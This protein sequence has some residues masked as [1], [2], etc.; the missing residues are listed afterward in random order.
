LELD[1]FA[2]D[3]NTKASLNGA[4]VTIEDLTDPDNPVLVQ[5]NEL[6]NNFNFSLDK[7]KKYRITATKPGYRSAT[8]DIDT[9]GVS[10]KISK[11][12]FLARSDINRLLPLAL[13]FDNDEPD[14]DS[15]STETSRR[16]IELA[17]AYVI[18]KPVFLQKYTQGLKTSDAESSSSNMEEFFEKDVRT[19]ANT[20]KTFMNELIN[21]LREGQK[22]EMTIRGYASPRFD[23]RYNL[24]LGQRRINSVRNEMM[25]YEAGVL[26]PYLLNKQLIMTEISYGEELSPLDIDDNIHDDKGSIYSLRASKERRVEIISVKIK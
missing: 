21:S 8:V 23:E 16:Y 4:K 5:V 10:G 19:G 7:N 18:R 1:V 2:F 6:G 17:E 9:R 25:E 24:I 22:I 26:A 12:L 3:E 13:Y 15:K 11:N 14:Q 20:F